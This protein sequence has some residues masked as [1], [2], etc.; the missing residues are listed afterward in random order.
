[1]QEKMDSESTATNAPWLMKKNPHQ[2]RISRAEVVLVAKK[3]NVNR[4]KNFK[5]PAI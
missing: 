4:C 2:Q 1:M 3:I 5:K